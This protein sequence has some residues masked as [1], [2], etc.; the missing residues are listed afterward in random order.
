[1]DNGKESRV[2]GGFMAF[3]EFASGDRPF[4]GRKTPKNPYPVDTPDRDEW[5]RGYDE[6]MQEWFA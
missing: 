6:A 2:I 1:V 5:Q 4:T 3:A